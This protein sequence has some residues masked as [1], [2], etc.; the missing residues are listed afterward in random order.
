[1]RT[2]GVGVIGMG[3]MGQVHSR[4]YNQINDRFFDAYFRPHLIICADAVEARA[5][6]AQERFGFQHFTTD[7]QDVMQNPN[8]EVVNITA[9]NGMH[10]ELNKAAAAAGKHIMCEKPV[11]RFPSETIASYEAVKDTG[12]A[13]AVGYNYRWAPMVQYAK[14]LIEGG[15]LGTITHYHGRFLNGYAGDP[16]GFFILAFR[17]GPRPWNIG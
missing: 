15:E 14:Q 17:G 4:A 16:M 8:V 12:L 5:K 2:I 3:W 1:M 9:P 10:L 13:A 6:E 7:W 11:G